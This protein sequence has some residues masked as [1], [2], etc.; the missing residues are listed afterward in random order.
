MTI[1]G[2]IKLFVETKKG[3]ENTTFQS[4]STSVST[5]VKDSEEF[6]NK[7]LEVRFSTENFKAETLRKLKDSKVY[8]LDVED[9]WLSVRS[10]KNADD[11]E[12]K[13]LYLFVN[14]ATL[15]GMKDKKVASKKVED[16]LPF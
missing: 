16:T 12:V 1:T 3:K 6:I 7:S 9:G 10:Y 13:V 5:R 14:K 4:F 11:V 15:K 2:L 8:D